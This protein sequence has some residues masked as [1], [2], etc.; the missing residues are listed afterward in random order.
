MKI[1]KFIFPSVLLA[2]TLTFVA[3]VFQFSTE[4]HKNTHEEN[5]TRDYQIYALNVPQE[6]SFA[7]E[8]VP[9]DQFFV[10]EKLDRELLVNTYWQSNTLLYLKRANK[11]FPVI[12]P[13][14]KEEGVPADFKYLALIESGLTQIVS[15]AGAVGFWQIMKATGSELGLEVNSQIDERYHVEK[16]TR[17]ACKYLKEAKEKYNSWTLAAASYNMGKNGLSKQLEKQKET[18]YYNLWL[19][20]ETSRY[21]YRILAAKTIL[22][23]PKAYG[24]N[25][26]EQDLWQLPETKIVTADTAIVNVADFA[27]QQGA[28]YQLFKTL[29]PWVRGNSI[30]NSKKKTYEFKITS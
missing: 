20:E 29:N 1:K 2:I 8:Q 15:P 19:N 17:A 7:G 12:E 14:L 9:T 6:I 11:W 28:S 18:D 4:P 5:F 13:I 10:K 25:I 24:F 16:S 3:S 23:N 22:S 26:R 21:V 30:T 27:H